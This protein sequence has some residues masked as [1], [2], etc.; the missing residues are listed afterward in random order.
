MARMSLSCI[1]KSVDSAIAFP[2][3]VTN[4]TVS[5]VEPRLDLSNNPTYKDCNHC[6]RT[7][8][9][10]KTGNTTPDP[11]PGVAKRKP[12]HFIT[13]SF[14]QPL[15]SRVLT[16]PKLMNSLWITSVSGNEPLRATEGLGN[17]R[18][19]ERYP[20]A[21][22]TDGK[23]RLSCRSLGVLTDRKASIIG[24]RATLGMRV[25]SKA[26]HLIL[27]VLALFIMKDLVRQL[28]HHFRPLKP[29][30]ENVRECI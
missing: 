25:Q 28:W 17:E 29:T 20:L 5:I 27:K 24:I 16:R 14:S 2:S 7:R 21:S 6:G 4:S 8:T 13:S 22:S 9:R 3:L 18:R 12:K 19:L 11:I 23:L 10:D 1:K 15:K 26:S 30:A